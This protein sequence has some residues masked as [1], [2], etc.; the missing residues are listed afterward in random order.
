ME[1]GPVDQ[2]ITVVASASSV[3]THSGELSYLVAEEAILNSR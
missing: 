1:V 3:K 2:T